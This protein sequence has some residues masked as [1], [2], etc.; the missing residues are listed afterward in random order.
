MP[1]YRNNSDIAIMYNTK[2]GQYS[3]PPHK[4]YEANI[5]VPYQELGLELVNPDYPPV[6]ESILLSG[7]FK[8]EKGLERKFSIR[9]C[10]KYR[11]KLTANTGRVKLYLGSSKMGVEV[12]ENYDCELNWSRA[13][14]V[15]VSGLDVVSDVRID[16]EVVE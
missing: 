14:F 4:N 10:N 3:F 11:L 2:G 15:R 6:P 16:A 7:T 8:F 1:T 13:P 9:H 12:S 5:W